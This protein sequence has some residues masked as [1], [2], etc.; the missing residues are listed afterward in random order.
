M[1]CND[2]NSLNY[3]ERGLNDK[4]VLSSG[5][6]FDAVITGHFVTGIQKMGAWNSL[7]LLLFAF[8]FLIFTFLYFPTLFQ[9][10][11]WL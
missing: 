10:V 9:A 2:F 3:F 11:R 8:C 5:S 4:V 1:L 7:I 6:S